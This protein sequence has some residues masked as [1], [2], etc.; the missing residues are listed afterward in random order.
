MSDA[1]SALRMLASAQRLFEEQDAQLAEK[2]RQLQVIASQLDDA[3]DEVATLR[4]RV[5]ELETLAA[6]G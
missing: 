4:G 6:R 2:E 1:R 3:L 5:M